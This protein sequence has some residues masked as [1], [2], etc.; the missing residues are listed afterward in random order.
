MRKKY[1]KPLEKIIE[2]FL[3]IFM[4]ECFVKRTVVDYA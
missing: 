3:M 2:C 4:F 1:S